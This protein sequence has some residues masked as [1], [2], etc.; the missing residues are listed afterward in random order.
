[1]CQ[2]QIPD[3]DTES[4]QL[5]RVA[6]IESEALNLLCFWAEGFS[7]WS[8]SGL[9]SPSCSFGRFRRFRRSVAG[10]I[11]ARLSPSERARHSPRHLANSAEDDNPFGR[12]RRRAARQKQ[13]PAKSN[14]KAPSR[15]VQ[16]LLREKVPLALTHADCSSPLLG[17]P[18]RMRS[19]GSLY[20]F[21]P[22]VACSSPFSTSI[23]YQCRSPTWTSA[24]FVA[25]RTSGYNVRHL[26]NAWLFVLHC[27]Y[28]EICGW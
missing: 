5:A 21:S 23:I 12:E 13:R 1:M 22:S 2:Q 10:V 26:V 4:A 28:F 8:D 6:L 3:A 9:A 24:R 25:F 20:S 27:G 16:R 15:A 18:V 17:P 7:G 11:G 19:T 14:G